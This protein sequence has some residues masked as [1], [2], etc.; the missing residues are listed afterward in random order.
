MIHPGREARQRTAISNHPAAPMRS[1]SWPG[2]EAAK[3]TAAPS[4]GVL[5]AAQDGRA[6]QHLLLLRMHLAKSCQT[7]VPPAR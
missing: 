3:S 2:R 1:C 5:T 7:Q 4:H 6:E